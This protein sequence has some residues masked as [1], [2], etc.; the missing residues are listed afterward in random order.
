MRPLRERVARLL[1]L[2]GLI[3]GLRCANP[4]Y[5]RCET[6]EDGINQKVEIER[7]QAAIKRAAEKAIRGTR[8]ER[9][10]RFEL[11]DDSRLAQGDTQAAKPKRG[12][13]LKK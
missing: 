1:L 9:S 7:M 2:I 5:E 3:G 13:R 11:R 12:S 6:Q 8:E 4:P 10:G